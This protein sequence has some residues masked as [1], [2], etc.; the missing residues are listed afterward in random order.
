[1]DG[2]MP[3]KMSF[4]GINRGS[5]P[6]GDANSVNYLRG[7]LAACLKLLSKIWPINTLGRARTAVLSGDGYPPCLG[8]S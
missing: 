8:D 7:V 5:N 2:N 6:L 1:M 4:H 3:P